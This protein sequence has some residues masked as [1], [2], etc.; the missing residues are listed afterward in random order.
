MDNRFLDRCE[1]LM[2]N[3]ANESL[4]EMMIFNLCD[5]TKG[6]MADIN[7]E[8]LK[9]F[10]AIEEEKKV[11]NSLKTTETSKHMNFTPVNA[12]TFKIWCDAYKERLAEERAATLDKNDKLTGKQLFMKNK[13]A[14]EDLTFDEPSTP[15][16]SQQF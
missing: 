12:E 5:I 14:F 16:S 7:E 8:V 2:Q 3:T 6:L 4:G 15:T 13:Q 9:K 1:T 11:D 10:D